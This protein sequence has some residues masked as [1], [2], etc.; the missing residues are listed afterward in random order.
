MLQAPM[1]L[2][3]LHDFKLIGHRAAYCL[4]GAISST[5]SS[6]GRAFST[7]KLTHRE[8]ADKRL[9]LKRQTNLAN[10]SKVRAASR[11]K[12]S[13]S[14]SK[15]RNRKPLISAENCNNAYF[16]IN[17]TRSTKFQPYAQPDMSQFIAETLPDFSVYF[18]DLFPQQK[19][20]LLDAIKM[21]REFACSSILNNA[22]GL[23]KLNL[24]LDAR[25]KKANKFMM[26]FSGTFVYPE[27]Y[28][29][30]DASRVILLTIDDQEAQQ[31]LEIGA[32]QAGGDRIYRK[33][34]DKTISKDEF[35]VL[36]SS[37][38]Y[39]NRLS[40]NSS[41]RIY[42]GQKFPSSSSSTLGDNG[43][44]IARNFINGVSYSTEYVSENQMIL[45]TSLGRLSMSDEAIKR[46]FDYL[47]DN[48]KARK[49]YQNIS[50]FILN[51]EITVY[52]SPEKFRIN[53]NNIKDPSIKIQ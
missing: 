42:L 35:D 33:L 20:D 16:D 41:F 18:T 38:N 36:V 11:E 45:S 2:N 8:D 28:K 13:S 19:S 23:I 21:H 40:V 44:E 46:N 1:A 31:A 34:I 24:W 32:Y 37:T 48:L 7:S 6:C 14:S 9:D 29:R 52:P 27:A 10:M 4:A 30:S 12:R 53:I 17:S 43:L 3:Y 50:Q 39:I 5:S 22:D 47:I 26:P 15:N 49:T 25:S 51:A